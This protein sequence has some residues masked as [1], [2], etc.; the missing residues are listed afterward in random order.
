[1][2]YSPAGS[3]PEILSRLE[4]KTVLFFFDLTNTGP[5][6]DTNLVFLDLM[7]FRLY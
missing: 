4:Y 7:V 1:M 3:S 5:G 6:E 2:I